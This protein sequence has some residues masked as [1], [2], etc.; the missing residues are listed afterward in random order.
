MREREGEEKLETCYEST[1]A[2]PAPPDDLAHARFCAKVVYF[3]IR[4][5]FLL[6]ATIFLKLFLKEVFLRLS[7]LQL[8]C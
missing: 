1:I 2:E 5:S 4:R 6:P 7:I 8:K 3:S